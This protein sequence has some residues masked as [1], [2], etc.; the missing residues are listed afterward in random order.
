SKRRQVSPRHS[1]QAQTTQDPVECRGGQFGWCSNLDANRFAASVEI[2]HQAGCRLLR[3]IALVARPPWKVEVGCQ[4]TT[5]PKRDLQ[6]GVLH[7]PHSQTGYAVTTTSNRRSWSGSTITSQAFPRWRVSITQRPSTTSSRWPVAPCSIR[8][9]SISVN[10]RS[11]I[12]L[13]KWGL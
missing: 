3:T 11:F 7:F 4:G 5:V 1:R 8:R 13:S 12:R 6:V 2:D 9:R 10:R